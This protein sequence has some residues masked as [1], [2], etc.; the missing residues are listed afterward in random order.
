MWC[1]Q[2]TRLE[3]S[4]FLVKQSRQPKKICLCLELLS[5]LKVCSWLGQAEQACLCLQLT[6]L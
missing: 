2:I 6:R 4:M 5:S 3:M 1:L